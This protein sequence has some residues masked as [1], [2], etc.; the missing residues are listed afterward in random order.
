MTSDIVQAIAERCRDD[1]KFIKRLNLNT[2]KE[3][4][5]AAIGGDLC[6]G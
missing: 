2:V 3:P 6:G 1:T 4:N 5:I